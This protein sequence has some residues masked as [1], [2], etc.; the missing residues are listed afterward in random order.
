MRLVLTRGNLQSDDIANGNFNVRVQYIND[1]RRTYIAARLAPYAR[2]QCGDWVRWLRDQNGRYIDHDA[3]YL[4]WRR[5]SDIDAD[6][7]RARSEVRSV[8]KP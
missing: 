1:V 7:E 2:T 3:V 6:E 8:S 4:P 5:Q